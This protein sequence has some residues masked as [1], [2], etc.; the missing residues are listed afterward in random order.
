MDISF[1]LFSERLRRVLAGEEVM[2]SDAAKQPIHNLNAEVEIV[3]SWLREFEYDISCLLF[4][5]IAEEEI[6]DPDLAT[7]MHKINCFTYESEKVIDTYINSITQQKSQSRYNKDICDALQRLQSRITEIKQ[8]VQQLKHIDPEIMDNFRSVEAESGYF[9]ASSSSKNRNTVGLDDRM[10][11]LLDLLIE[12]PTQLSVVAILDSIGLDKTAFTA[13]AYNSSYVKH[14]FDYLA[15]IPAPYQYDPDQLLDV[16]TVILLPF[17]MLSKIKDKDYEMKK[18]ILGEYLMTKRY[19]IVLDDV[20]SADVLDAI[21]EILPDNQNG[22]RVLI[23]LTLI[24]MVTSFQFENGENVRLD[25]VPTRGPLRVSYQG[26]PFLILYHGSI[27]LEQNIEEA[28]EGPMG[29]LTVISCKLPFRL[30]PCFLYLSVFPAHLEIST[31][32][33]YQLWIAEGFIP[34]NSEATAE[35]YLEQLINRGF[36][37]ARRRRAGGTINT[38]SVR[39]RC[40]PALLTVAIEAEF[41]FLS[42]MVSERK[43]KKNVKRINVF[44]KQSD[45]VHFVDDDSHMHSLLYFT[46]KSDHLDPIDWGIICLML[47]FLRV[48][49]LGS[50]VLIQYPSGIENLFLLRYLKLNIPSLKIL[51]SSLLSNLLNLY[52]LDMPFSYI[53]HTA[54]EFWKMNKLRHLNFGSIT[55]PAHPGKYCGSLENLNFISALHPCCCTEDILGRLPNLRNLRIRGDLSYNQ[56][57]LSKSLC[58]LSCLESLKLANESKM[59]RLSKIVLAEYLFPHGLTHLSFSNTDLMDDPMPALEKL[60]LLQV[61]KLK[62]NSYSGR[63]LNCGSDGFPNL[64][65]L[66]LKS[67]LWLE[68]WTMGIGAMPKLECLIINP[69]AYLKKMPEQL[70]CIKS[71]NKFDCWWPQPELRQK[72]REFED[73]EQCGIQLFP[74]GI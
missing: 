21:Q 32:Q 2:L 26:W 46:S 60:P 65:V 38:C 66:H 48:L 72:L 20:W 51:P 69:C 16:V 45:F 41:I 1:R 18:V 30:K 44:D 9:P 52:T 7:V 67:M 74:Y 54:D 4:Q 14:Y 5:K 6:D 23:T 63:K 43:S 40:R 68:E 53:D 13:E 24:E 22:S 62:Q 35:K 11:E 70:R 56:S 27:S 49:D 8:R 3:T 19:L 42:F 58:R 61:L 50:L 73:K 55:L 31:R 34:D 25:I 39:G 17:S 12:G 28:I 33:L 29:R 47:E 10:E 57:L 15:W 64:K 71:L 59:P 36:V 37:D